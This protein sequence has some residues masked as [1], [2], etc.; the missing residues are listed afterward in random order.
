MSDNRQQYIE[1]L[2]ALLREQGEKVRSNKDNKT[3][4]QMLERADVLLDLMK[5]LKD[6][7]ENVKVLNTYWL[8]KHYKEK[9]NQYI[10]R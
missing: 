3:T 5:F 1:E 9:Y 10:D 6:Y 8:D 4:L 7:E 2:L